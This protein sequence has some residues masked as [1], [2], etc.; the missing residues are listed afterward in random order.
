MTQ[1]PPASATLRSFLMRFLDAPLACR[2]A[3]KNPIEEFRRLE[4]A[5]SKTLVESAGLPEPF[6]KDVRRCLVE[7]RRHLSKQ[8]RVLEDIQTGPSMVHEA[9]G[10]FIDQLW[11]SQGLTLVR[12]ADSIDNETAV[13]L[14]ESSDTKIVKR[15]SRKRRKSFVNKPRPLT[16]KQLETMQIVRGRYCG[17]RSTLR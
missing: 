13:E 6:R 1:S 15:P 16:A 3:S 14:I 11:A 12:L 8:V 2:C 9:S 17:S 4:S 5:A 10:L 7:L